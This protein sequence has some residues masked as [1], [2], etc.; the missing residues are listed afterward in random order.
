MGVCCVSAEVLYLAAHAA[1]DSG[2]GGFGAVKG[3]LPAGAFVPCLPM[4]DWV[5]R[6]RGGS[7]LVA[8]ADTAAAQLALA[9]IPGWIVKQIAN[10]AQ[11]WGSCQALVRHDF[12]EAKK[13]RR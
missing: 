6:G 1:T 13:K 8:V 4:L 10:V 11:L 7:R 12:P 3:P 5:D 2:P 9:M